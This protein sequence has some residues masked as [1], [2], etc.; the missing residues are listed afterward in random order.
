MSAHIELHHRKQIIFWLGVSALFFLIL[1]S[2]ENMLLPFILGMAIAYFLDPVVDRLENKGWSRTAGVTFVLTMFALGFA[3]IVIL[4][5]PTLYVQLL[6]LQ[7]SLPVYIDKLKDMMQTTL[8]P[9][10]PADMVQNIDFDFAQISPEY[11][12][13]A[14]SW[15]KK[16]MQTLW[17]SGQALFSFLS[18]LFITPVVAFYLL[19]DWDV[20]LERMHNW[21]PKDHKKTITQIMK[22]IDTTLAGFLRGQAMVCVLLGMFYSVGLMIAGLNFGLF[23]GIGS[24]LIAFIPYVGSM[25]GMGVALLVAWFQFGDISM[26]AIIGA[27]FLAGQTL[28]GNFLTPKL[29]GEKIGLHAVWV[30]FALMAGGELLG[31]VGVMVAVPAAAIIGVLTRFSLDL[32]LKSD[33]YHGKKT[34]A[35]KTKA[36]PRKKAVS[37]KKKTQK[38]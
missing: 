3:A 24:G 29:I 38:A 11:Q 34:A 32:Y 17:S 31:F 13:L 15:A 18:I 2:L 25:L 23:I 19:R 28:E 35:K 8:A 37:R 14:K 33:Y 30:I 26:M 36:K 10:L 21:L 6:G 27:I 1:W 7:D 4:I 20:M 22:D 9:L 12:D 5:V 16:L